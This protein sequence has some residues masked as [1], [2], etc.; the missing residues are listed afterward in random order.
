V[1]ITEMRLFFRVFTIGATYIML[2]TAKKT[3]LEDGQFMSIPLFLI[4]IYIL[5][6][7]I[8]KLSAM[9]WIF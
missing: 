6:H 3:Q 1:D 2:A 4:F 8:G 7:E 5:S 9:P